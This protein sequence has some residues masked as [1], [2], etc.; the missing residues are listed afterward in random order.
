MYTS[1]LNPWYLTAACFHEALNFWF[2][3]KTICVDDYRL[4]LLFN[5]A[6]GRWTFPRLIVTTSD[7][8]LRS[9]SRPLVASGSTSQ[10]A[11]HGPLMTCTPTRC[12]AIVF[13]CIE[14]NN[15]T[16]NK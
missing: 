6:L 1:V 12:N 4:K 5:S 3:Y 8:L 15:E 7:L 10:Q 14:A 16:T 11:C 9:I 13:N 2:I